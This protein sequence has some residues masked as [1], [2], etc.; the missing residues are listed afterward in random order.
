MLALDI[1][2]GVSHEMVAATD[3]GDYL[4]IKPKQASH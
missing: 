3:E 1:E 2:K 4:S